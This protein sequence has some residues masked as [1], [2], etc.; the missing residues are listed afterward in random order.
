MER[1]GGGTGDAE[2]VAALSQQEDMRSSGEKKLTSTDMNLV[3]Q[4]CFEG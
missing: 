3:Q 1:G 4:G 2:K